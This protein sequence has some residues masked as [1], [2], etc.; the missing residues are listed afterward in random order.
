MLIFLILLL[1]VIGCTKSHE[2]IDSRSDTAVEKSTVKRVSTD[3]GSSE[4]VV[5]SSRKEQ[6]PADVFM[7]VD[8]GNLSRAAAADLLLAID[9][10]LL[11]NIPLKFKDPQK[12]WFGLSKRARTIVYSP[13]RVAESELSSYESLADPKWKDRLC[14]RTAKKVYNQSLVAM[15]IAKH[16]IAKTENIVKAWVANLATDPFSNDTKAMEAIVAGQCDL[17]VVNTYYLGRMLRKNPDIALKVFWPNQTANEENLSGVHVNISGAAVIK[18]SK[19]IALAKD[20]LD[21]LVSDRAQSILA[22]GNLEYPVI[23]QIEIDPLIAAWGSFNSDQQN[24]AKAG[25]LQPEAVKLMDR[26]GYY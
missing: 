18:H 6:P 3:E 12:R 15:L 25:R 21:W 8:A 2:S 1:A 13:E 23:E 22:N 7:T 16:G 17:T 11:N 26:A 14:L 20:F 5:Y 24:I 19:N 4:L 9:S 10:P